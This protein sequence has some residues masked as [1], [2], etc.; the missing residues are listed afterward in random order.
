MSKQGSLF[1]WT[2]QGEKPMRFD[3]PDYDEKLDQARLTGQNL[4][5][6]NLMRD[7]HWRSLNEIG[8]SLD[9]PESSVSAQLRH[10]RKAR[11][12]GHT[13]NKKRR[14]NSGTWEYQLI[15]NKGRNNDRV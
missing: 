12:G 7:R 9:E 3:G 13:I 2:E 10:L 11:F 14:G 5:I 1:V 15:I 8:S 6:F 4:K